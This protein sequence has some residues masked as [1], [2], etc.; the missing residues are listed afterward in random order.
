VATAVI[1]VTSGN[2]TAVSA[3]SSEIVPADHDGQ[4]KR[5][6]VHREQGVAQTVENKRKITAERLSDAV[7]KQITDLCVEAFLTRN[8]HGMEIS[9]YVARKLREP[10]FDER[11]VDDVIVGAL[12]EASTRLAVHEQDVKTVLLRAKQAAAGTWECI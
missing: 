9:A 7:R 4:I 2:P 12:C 3:A 10:G 1:A 8:R 11:L 5:K 6:T